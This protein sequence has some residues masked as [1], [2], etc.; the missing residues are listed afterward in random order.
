MHAKVEQVPADIVDVNH[1]SARRRRRRDNEGQRLW[2]RGQYERVPKQRRHAV[3]RNRPLGCSCVHN[4]A[5]TRQLRFGTQSAQYGNKEVRGLRRL[6]LSPH[7]EYRVSTGGNP[8]DTA[9]A[10][11][12]D[13]G[14]GRQGLWNDG[15]ANVQAQWQEAKLRELRQMQL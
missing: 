12:S 3:D 2:N 6:V 14:A 4:K 7:S 8:N 10:E 5:A 1:V 11:G 15:G 13:K 9:G